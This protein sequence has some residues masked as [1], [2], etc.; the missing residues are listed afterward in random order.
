MGPGEPRGIFGQ[1]YDSA[2]DPQGGQFQVN[3]YINNT[4]FYPSVAATGTG[5]FVVVWTSYGQDGSGAGM[6]GRRL[7]SDVDTPR[8]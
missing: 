8:P 4:Q 1:R 2:G 3:S 6:F 7:T 5:E